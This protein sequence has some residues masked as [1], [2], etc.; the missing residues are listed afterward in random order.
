MF[1]PVSLFIGLR[2]A[3]LAKG[4]GFIS[5]ISFFSI[6]GITLGIIALICVTSVM[7]G[8]EN[9]L[10][11]SML[12]TE[13]HLILSME[14]EHSELQQQLSKDQRVKSISRFISNEGLVVSNSK[15][16]GVKF[17]GVDETS[18]NPLS[19]LLSDNQRKQL[20]DN[21]YS[22][23]L[24]RRLAN[25]LKV[26]RGDNV[27]LML[28]S[29]SRFTPVGRMPSQRIF[30]VVEII[31]RHEVHNQMV[32]MS[33][34]S[35]L[36]LSRIKNSAFHSKAIYLDDPFKLTDL[37]NEYSL[38]S[39]I[40]LSDWRDCQGALFSAVAIEKRIMSLL[41]GLIILVAIFN[42]LSALTMMVSEKQS[43]IAILQTLGL[44]PNG[45]LQV[46]MVQGLFNGVV[47]SILGVA[48]GLLIAIHI[49]EVLAF[50]GIQ[51]LAGMRLPIDISSMQVITI[52]CLSILMSYLAT[53]YPAK[54]AAK[55]APA[56]VLRYE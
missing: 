36:K 6:A 7:N 26:T 31:D 32:F 53:F 55:L 29:V 16:V 45:V 11:Y 41:L 4:N 15:L 34:A 13:P 48:S 40:K 14:D 33:N 43:E 23:A 21:K 37:E 19:E 39:E 56:Q 50:L 3:K 49:N 51:L 44:T 8:F 10:K 18:S 24:T 47:G 42:I 38:L 12:Q 30:K 1:Q 5:F 54:R 22:V 27:R 46:F 35:L 17:Y 2:Y 20:K 52:F 28:P 25:D 9:R